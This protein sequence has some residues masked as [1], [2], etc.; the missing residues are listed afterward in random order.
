[1]KITLEEIKRLEK[2]SALSY[3][4][5]KLESFVKDFEQIAQF[6]EQVTNGDVE[7]ANVYGRIVK[8]EQ[9]RDDVVIPSYSQEQILANAPEK[10][11]GAFVVPKVVD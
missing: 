1:M 2:L 3:D 10:G 5:E 9:L 7:E 6:V 4:D 11:E 8:I